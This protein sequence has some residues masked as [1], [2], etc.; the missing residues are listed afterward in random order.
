MEVEVK[1][2]LKNPEQVTTKLNA[3][4]KKD[5]T[6]EFQKDTYFELKSKLLR[7]RESRSGNF[8]SYKERI[9]DISCNSYGTKIRDAEPMKKILSLFGFKQAKV[10]E[11]TRSTWLY[12]DFEIALDHVKGLGYFIEIEAQKRIN[13]LS[14]LRKIDAEVAEQDYEGYFKP[15][16]RKS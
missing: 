11:K 14:V 12:N 4:A 7:I 13:F 2:P 10:V 8:L 15:S 1:F 9:D 6:N 5:K 3:L 16:N